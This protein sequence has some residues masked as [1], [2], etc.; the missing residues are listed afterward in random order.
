[1]AQPGVERVGDVID[2]VGGEP[3]MIQTETDRALGQLMRVV[4]VRQLAVFDA[5]EAFFL[6]GRDQRAVDQ[7]GRG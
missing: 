3:G 1:L 2:I 6:D 5:I 4:D 7:Q